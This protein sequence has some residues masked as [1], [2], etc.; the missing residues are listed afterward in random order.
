MRFLII[1]LLLAGCTTTETKYIKVRL[2]HDPRPTLPKISSDELK[3]LSQ[4]TYQK[5]YDRERLIHGWAV[6]METTIDST[7]GN[8]GN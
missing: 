1:A 3:C 4:Q 8:D 6:G 7:G 5:L 2:T